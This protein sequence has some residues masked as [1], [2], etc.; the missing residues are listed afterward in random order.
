MMPKLRFSEFNMPWKQTTLGS[1][2]SHAAY[3]MNSS[4][5][6]FDGVN[7][8]IRIT[9]IDDD[10]REF[11][12]SPL[13]TPSGKL[14]NKYLL[15]K[16][17]IVFARTGASVGKSYLYKQKDG[18]LYFAGFL[19]KLTIN[20]A[21]PYFV[22]NQTLTEKYRKWVKIYSMRSGQP[23]IN[24]EEYKEFEFAIPSLE[25]QTKIAD[26]LS[27]VDEKISLL[28]QQYDLLCQYKKGMMQKIFSQKI[29]FK[30][31][32]GSDFLDWRTVQ[33]SE[34]LY[35]HKKRN[36]KLIY[37][38]EQ[39]LSVSGDVGIV[40]Q[41]ELLGRSYAGESVEN[42]HIVH[43]GDIVYTKSPLKEN[44]FGII[45]SN[46]GNSGIVSTLYAV[47]SCL[48]CIDHNYIDYYFSRKEV[49][50]NYLKPLINKG[51]KNDMKVNNQHVLTGDIVLPSREEQEKIV[52]LLSMLDDKIAVKKAELDKL[53]TWKQGLLQQMFV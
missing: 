9:D 26:F 28:N 53:K 4:A 22:Y 36:K 21:N 48:D 16:G 52:S 17:D 19:I 33:L 46:K 51:A 12:P 2:S 45:K 14:E 23:G 39:V 34:C 11:T 15:N 30:S 49:V 8:Y 6:E 47:Y 50:N 44:P 32:D 20:K 3:G 43:Q 42:Y 41:I 10:T 1:V 40:N 27:S 5:I 13:T 29:R 35:E 24:A 7:K 25:E 38:K 37:S 18:R 31:N